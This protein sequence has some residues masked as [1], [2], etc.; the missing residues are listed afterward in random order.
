MC[1][2]L[3]IILNNNND[4]L[5]SHD[6]TSANGLADQG[7]HNFRKAVQMLIIILHLNNQRLFSHL[8]NIPWPWFLIV[9]QNI[10]KY[11]SAGFFAD[12]PSAVS[13]S[14][15]L[16]CPSVMNFPSLRNNLICGMQLTRCGLTKFWVKPLS[17]D[18]IRGVSLTG[19]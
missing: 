10:H 16:I 3:N 11:P 4:E 19:F 1:K 15:L 5:Y 18:I 13:S 8:C 6:T 12:F 2:L 14:A 17:T 7:P 9:G